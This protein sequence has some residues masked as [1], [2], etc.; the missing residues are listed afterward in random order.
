MKIRIYVP[1]LLLCSTFL[2][3]LNSAVKQFDEVNLHLQMYKSNLDHQRGVSNNI[4]W[5]RKPIQ[6]ELF[7]Y[8]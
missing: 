8:E 6:K 1:L 5:N 7:F 2:N 4:G 3:T